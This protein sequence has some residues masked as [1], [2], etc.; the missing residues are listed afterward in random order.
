MSDV[1]IQYLERST[2]VLRFDLKFLPYLMF[3]NGTPIWSKFDV[4]QR[5]E[6]FLVNKK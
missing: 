3:E 2:E 5:H 6:I 1:I 4:L